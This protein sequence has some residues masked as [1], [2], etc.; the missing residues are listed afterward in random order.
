MLSTLALAAAF[1]VA[2]ERP[3]DN[4][5]TPDEP[6]P[7]EPQEPD[8]PTPEEPDEP[9]TPTYV[10]LSEKGTSNCYLIE[11]DGPYCFDA[12]VAGNGVD[13]PS[14]AADT[15]KVVWQ[16]VDGLVTE[17]CYEDG[18][19]KFDLSDKAGS[20]LFAAVDSEGKILWS[21]HIWKPKE[22]LESFT[23]KTGYEIASL[24]IG[25]LDSNPGSVDSY[26]MFYQWGRKD[27]FPAGPTLTGD[28]STK[29]VDLYDMDGE[30]V[31]VSYS[32]WGSNSSN[33][34][35]YSIANPTVVLAGYPLPGSYQDWLK[36]ENN[37][38]W[39]NPD[40][41]VR[42]DENEYP[43]KGSKS[44]Y[45]PCPVGW[46]VPPVDV[47]RT[48]TP[49]G[50]YD[51]DESQFDVDGE[52]NYGY[53]M[54]MAEGS[55]YFPASGRYYGAYGMLYGTVSGL[56][57]NYWSNAPY[58]SDGNQMG[59]II[60]AFQKTATAASMSPLAGGA[61]SDAYPVRCIRDL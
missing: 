6:T 41:N 34:L 61:K 54:N 14:F 4:P 56:W 26:G 59:S 39:G 1:M 30:V 28:T 57:G 23:T 2:C 36:D 5:S 12:T 18:V 3:E 19:I 53:Y 55:S 50:G 42:N 27:P 17:F 51:V 10:N 37:S 16:T 40:G 25:A 29:P 49:S 7:E 45:D 44:C 15:A 43:N 52:F 9:D 11:V 31:K 20:A 60:V 8:E 13:A 21:W 48:A 35:E 46:R 38:L 24:N 32:S 58:A 33:N 22:T 47:L